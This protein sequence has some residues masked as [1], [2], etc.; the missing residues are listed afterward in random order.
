MRYEPA[1][2]W[3]GYYEEL[4]PEIRQEILQANLGSLPDDGTNEFRRQLFEERYRD[5]KHHARQ[6]D[7][8]LWNYLYLT[9]LFGKRDGLFSGFRRETGKI[10]K[11]FHL[12]DPDSLTDGQKTALYLEFYNAAVR[13][14]DTCQSDRYASRLMGLI[15]AS[16]AE[17]QSKACG[18][19][20][21]MSRGMAV[22]AGREKEMELFCQALYDAL[23]DRYPQCREEYRALDEQY[24]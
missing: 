17:K 10:L 4:E 8:Y 19:I 15:R 3:A 16:D 13:Y 12:D 1:S 24:I 14:L 11:L 6:V 22:A 23:T 5:P 20:W 9:D 7:N 2:G 21:K 18:E